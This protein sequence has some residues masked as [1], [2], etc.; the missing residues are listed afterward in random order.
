[1]IDKRPLLEVHAL[2]KTFHLGNSIFGVGAAVRAVD[3]VDLAFYPGESLAIVGESGCGK[4]TLARCIAGLARPTSGEVRFEGMDIWRLK[5]AARHAFQRRVQPVFQD[6][7]SSLDPRWTVEQTIREP[8]D[9]YAVGTSDER[10][11]RVAELMQHVGLPVSFRTRRPHELSGGQCQRV[12]IAAALALQPALLV[13]DEPVS[14]LDVSVRAQI[15]NLLARL[16]QELGLALV[17]ITHDLAVVEH[18]SDRIA[19]M[20]LGRIVEVGLTRQVLE[21][22]IH[23]Y[24]K[25]LIE[26]IPYPDPSRKIAGGRLR[27]EVPSAVA[28]PPGCHFHPRCPLAVAKCSTVEPT[29]TDFGGGRVAACHVAEANRGSR[30]PRVRGA[31]AGNSGIGTEHSLSW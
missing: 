4:S 31:D 21:D 13:A 25:A 24:T 9:I 2:V 17:L 16:R 29:L 8:L 11:K 7:L 18:I 27:G 15:L 20:Y 26:S 3:G 5:P 23:P 14:A 1:M 12:G 22:P 6:P 30:I 28:P 19:V 10:K